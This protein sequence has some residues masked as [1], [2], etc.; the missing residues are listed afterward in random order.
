M[1]RELRRRSSTRD[2]TTRMMRIVYSGLSTLN[3]KRKTNS[4]VDPSRESSQNLLLNRTTVERRCVHYLF[5]SLRSHFCYPLHFTSLLSH[6]LRSLCCVREFVLFNS[7]FYT[8]QN[9]LVIVVKLPRNWDVKV[10]SSSNLWLLFWKV[11]I[12][13]V[14]RLFIGTQK[15]R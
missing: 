14:V 3:Q 11:S 6:N 10:T 2:K 15:T 8:L 7:E 13:L 5:D 4:A 12:F 9:R 1:M